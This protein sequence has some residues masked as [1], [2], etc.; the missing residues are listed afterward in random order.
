M[1]KE[2]SL[3]VHFEVFEHKFSTLVFAIGFR[4]VAILCKILPVV[5]AYHN[6]VHVHVLI[7]TYLL[8]SNN[9]N[10]FL[11]HI[12]KAY[13]EELMAEVARLGCMDKRKKKK[14]AKKTAKRLQKA[15]PSLASKF[16]YPPKDK[17][18]EAHCSRFNLK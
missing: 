5:S 10:I 8:S 18:V 7:H 3:L 12:N 6:A 16:E 17:I 4:S 11:S 2:L 1:A 13:V 14:R 9:F 15:P